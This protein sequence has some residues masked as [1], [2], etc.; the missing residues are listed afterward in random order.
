M[1]PLLPSVSVVIVARRRCPPLAILCQLSDQ[2]E[3]LF[4]DFEFV[5]VATETDEAAAL[6]LKDLVEHLPDSLAVF[7]G[8]PVHD[9]VARLI[10]IDHAVSDYVLFAAPTVDEIASLAQLIEPLR[11]GSDLVIGRSPQ[12]VERGAIGRALFLLFRTLFRLA[13]GKDFE[14]QPTAFRILSRAAALYIAT[15][16]DGEVL[17]RARTLGSG[18]PVVEVS[19]SSES[20]RS[21]KKPS[22]LRDLG[23][24]A[25]LIATGSTT[26]LRASSYIALAGGVASAIYATYVIL[27]YFFYSDVQPGW[28]TLSLQLSGMLLLFSVQF[29]LLS[30][31]VMQLAA[32]RGAS[33]RPHLIIREVRS[34]RSR[35]ISR[36]NVVDHQGRFEP[37]APRGLA[38]EPRETAAS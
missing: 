29:L 7:L 27:I 28:T 8:E 10:G 24:A 17:V 20:R 14:D 30:E 35:R 6:Q 38:G 23:R 36:L 3:R 16:R 9:D 33:P 12:A 18:F 15:R 26:L 2:L 21:R 1:K 11:S 25:R 4:A 34:P 19:V 22:L 31:H 13:A 5:L 32:D 37:G